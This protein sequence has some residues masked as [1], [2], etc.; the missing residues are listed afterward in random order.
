[1]K[2]Y[3]LLLSAVSVLLL[4]LYAIAEALNI[5][6]LTDPMPLLSRGRAIAAIVGT[7]L[8]IA[9]VILPAPSSVVMVAYGALFGVVIGTTLSLVG[10][11]GSFLVGYYIGKHSLRVAQTF[12]SSDDL[13][14]AHSFLNK[15][16]LIAIVGTRPLPI[17]SETMSIAAGMATLSVG[18]ALLAAIVGSVPEALLFAITGAVAGSF[19]NMS[20]VFVGVIVLLPVFWIVSARLT[21]TSA[22]KSSS[23]AS[24]P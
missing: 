7:G 12:L 17:A 10:R 6:L 23:K 1:M 2:R 22:R 8:L 9:D 4:A 13:A 3:V 21:K 20:Y 19:V 15:W 24:N 11:A 16:G 5:A 18:W 14:R